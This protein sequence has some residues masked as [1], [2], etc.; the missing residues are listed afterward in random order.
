[1]KC[2]K[3]GHCKSKTKAGNCANQLSECEYKAKGVD[4]KD[5]GNNANTRHGHSGG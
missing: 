1:M 3:K 2:T 4:K 5:D